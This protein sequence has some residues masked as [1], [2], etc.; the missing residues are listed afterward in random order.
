MTASTPGPRLSDE[1]R[2]QTGVLQQLHDRLV[3]DASAAGVLDLA[4]RT[5]DTPIGVL[6]VAATDTGLV[7][8]A[9][10]REGL[11]DVLVTL[12]ARIS[13]RILHAPQR[14]ED[15]AQQLDEYFAGR[16][17]TFDL[18]LDHR[19]SDGFRMKVHQYLPHIR[20]GHTMTYKQVAEQVGNPNAVRAVGTACAT[21]PLPV[22]V[23]CHR[24]LRSDGTVGGYLGGTDAKRSLL[25]LERAA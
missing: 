19:L 14:L 20:F 7:R 21:N 22:V 12:A 13:P 1:T 23:P 24:V 5:L 3:T 18:P 10:A 25:D 2:I 15:V 16:R 4:Y 9:F 11:D 17:T 6:L 8:V